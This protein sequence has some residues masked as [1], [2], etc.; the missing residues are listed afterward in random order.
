[1]RNLAAEARSLRSR[2]GRIGQRLQVAA[3]GRCGRVRGYP[4]QAER[5]QKQRCLQHLI[6]RLAVVEQRSPMAI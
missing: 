3:N 5:W 2:I 1:M 6:A 4:T